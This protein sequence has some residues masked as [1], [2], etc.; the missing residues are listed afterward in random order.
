MSSLPESFLYCEKYRPQTIDDCILPD[1]FREYFNSMVE[2][3][4][5]QH[6]LLTGSQGTGKCLDPNEKIDIRVSNK[7][8]SPR[9]QDIL[10]NHIPFMWNSN[11][12][13]YY[14]TVTLFDLFKSLDVT[15]DYD[16]VTDVQDDIFVKSVNNTWVKIEG[17]I[18]KQDKK[19]K[20][21]TANNKTFICGEKHIVPTSSG[22]TFLR[23]ATEI[24]DEIEKSYI[25][26]TL[27]EEVK[28][29][30]VFDIAVPYPHHYCDSK[31]LLHHNTTIAKA[32]CKELGL[33]YMVINASL[34]GNIDTLRGQIQSFASTMSFHSP[35][36]VVILDE[37]DYLN[38]FSK[39]QKIRTINI[40]NEIEERTLEEL[41][42]SE[43][44]LLSYDFNKN[45]II[46][47]SGIVFKSGEKEIFEV[48]LDDG[49]I[50]QCT[51]D[52]HF[53][54]NIGDMLTIGDNIE[55]FSL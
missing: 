22:D 13:E 2:K 45:E 5:L 43:V 19:V 32:L 47:T 23:D 29:G 50:I 28:Y 11:R 25:A 12:E 15:S 38:C 33:E 37:A 36:K 20:V 4:Q 1:R 52:H 31:G 6:L 14:F 16:V 39:N 8:Y 53:F 44:K 49:S 7:K 51:A 26:I 46:H 21:T 9:I 41:C 17:V 54:N 35:Y 10:D 40:N 42:D 18:K 27:K 34:N 48:E 55:L 30:D 3:G 24:Y